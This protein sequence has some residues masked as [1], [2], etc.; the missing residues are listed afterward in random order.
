MLMC[1]FTLNTDQMDA[2]GEGLVY[3]GDVKM[4]LLSK[5]VQNRQNFPELIQKII[6]H[7]VNE[8]SVVTK[9]QLY[10]VIHHFWH[11]ISFMIIGTVFINSHLKIYGFVNTK[12]SINYIIYIT[13]V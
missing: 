13:E 2:E 3:S 7:K 10:L 4:A 11:F 1:L 9:N 5:T 12:N 8:L 6:V